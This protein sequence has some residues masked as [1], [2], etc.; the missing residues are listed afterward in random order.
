MTAAR[1]DSA[2]T[3]VVAYT[4]DPLEDAVAA[5][6]ESLAKNLPW[7]IRFEISDHEGRLL[8]QM[9]RRVGLK[10]VE[11]RGVSAAQTASEHP[12][13]PHEKAAASAVSA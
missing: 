2:G 8:F 12:G 3:E 13:A 5:A 10:K 7:A 6:K 4:S 11:R 9:A 1:D